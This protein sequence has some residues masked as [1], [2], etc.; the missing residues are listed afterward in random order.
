MPPALVPP[1]PQ[2]GGALWCRR[3]GSSRA[4]TRLHVATCGCCALQAV[5][6]GEAKVLVA[7]LDGVDAASL[8]KAGT[9]LAEAL[10]DPSAVVLGSV[11]EGKVALV[12]AFSPALVKGK[13]MQAGKFVGGLAKICGGG[14]GGKPHLAQAGGRMP[15]KLPEALDAARSQ[16]QEA[17]A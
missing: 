11:T 6:I 1:L 7:T 17:L 14:G 4:S 13:K 2:E 8:Q 15:D 10:A 16:L 3:T 12:V 5:Q 9:A